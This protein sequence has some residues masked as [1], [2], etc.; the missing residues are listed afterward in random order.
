MSVTVSVPHMVHKQCYADKVN[1]ICCLCFFYHNAEKYSSERYNA[2]FWHVFM[3]FIK[4]QALKHSHNIVCPTSRTNSHDL[5][6]PFF[7]MGCSVGM[8][9]YLIYIQ[10]I[11]NLCKVNFSCTF[12]L[13]PF[14]WCVFCFVC[15]QIVSCHVPT[16]QL[17]LC[18]MEESGYQGSG[19]NLVRLTKVY[20][21]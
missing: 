10:S 15:P 17:L 7:R 9:I 12:W 14:A 8:N 1:I 21:L 6:H 20:L 2:N 13:M 16:A 11:A 18:P 5:W 19:P 3:I 4:L